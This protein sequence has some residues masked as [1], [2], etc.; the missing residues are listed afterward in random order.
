MKFQFYLKDNEAQIDRRLSKYWKSPRFKRQK[1]QADIK[2][3]HDI[4]AD[5]QKALVA[6][7]GTKNGKIR[8]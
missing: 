6:F 5:P 3:Y 2:V 1:K 7:K 8:K 4:Y